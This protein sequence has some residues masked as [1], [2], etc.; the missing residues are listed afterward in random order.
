[1]RGSVAWAGGD[2]EKRRDSAD[3]T[4][5]NG[6]PSCV[7]LVKYTPRNSGFSLKRDEAKMVESVCCTTSRRPTNCCGSP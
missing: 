3:S 4:R 5:S 7:P 2:T 1:V 6:M